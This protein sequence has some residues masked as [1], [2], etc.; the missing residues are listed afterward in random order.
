[1]WV[2]AGILGLVTLGAIVDGWRVQ[3]DVRAGKDTL[4][5]LDVETIRAGGG[6]AE[7]LHGAAD[8][9]AHADHVAR[10]SPFLRVAS[11][12]P[13]VGTQV[14]GVRALTAGVHELGEAA[15]LT[16]DRLDRAIAAA[17]KEPRARVTLL[18]LVDRELQRVE[19]VAGQVDLGSA[20]GLAGPLADAHREAADALA[21]VP[22]R[23]ADVRPQL[24]ALRSL[25][26]GPTQYLIVV[27]NNAEMRTGAGMP[28]QAGPATITN[29]DITLGDFKSTVDDLFVRNP[30]GP[31]AH[32]PA[33]VT[34]TY[35]RWFIGADFP[36]TAVIPSFTVTA[37]LYAGLAQQAQGWN[38]TG[39]AHIDVVALANLLRVVGPVEFG[40]Q[41]YTADTAPQLVLN[42]AYIEFDTLDERAERVSSQSQLANAL[43]DALQSRDVDLL[44]LVEA[45]Q[46]SA[47]GRHLM[48]WS[49]DPALQDLYL[50]FGAG[51]Q[52]PGEAT[53]VSF[54]NTAANKLDW[55]LQP[56]IRVEATRIDELD[57]W[58]V[59]IFATITNP[60]PERTS[61]YID[62]S[63]QGLKNGTHRTYLDFHL[64]ASAT[65]IRLLSPVTEQGHRHPI[66]DPPRAVPHRRGPI[67]RSGIDHR[68]RGHALGSSPTG[69]V[70]GQRPSVRR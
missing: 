1:L 37:P 25:L 64:P 15:R 30:T 4:D 57:Q 68:P 10:R 51:G 6:I 49:P 35:P 55:Y 48:L 13:G 5:H 47:A 53:M 42:E 22:A 52:M 23:V 40:G 60:V 19:A 18:D 12:V 70:D 61:G 28:L 7:A 16:G 33:D 45:L 21:R 62:G 41:T 8:N 69:A 26:T 17:A 63:Y 14:R 50:S 2:A 39:V 44:A 59:Q 58:F 3:R 34:A 31:N 67:S 56:E 29:G 9:L 24:A 43:F 46:K 36:E 11:L 20:D 38:V 32:P 27:G 65:G 66:R 54:N